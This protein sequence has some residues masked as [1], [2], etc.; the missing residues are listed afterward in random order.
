M[1]LRPGAHLT[2]ETMATRETHY[3][4]NPKHTRL[5]GTVLLFYQGP[6][7][8]LSTIKL[9]T[10]DLNKFNAIDLMKLTTVDVNES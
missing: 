5:I 4:V 7:E 3:V 1:T 8:K 9:S 2:Y 10:R 6:N